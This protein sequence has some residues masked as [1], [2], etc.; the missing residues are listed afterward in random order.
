LACITSSSRKSLVTISAVTE[1]RSCLGYAMRCGQQAR[2]S[3]ICHG[4][5]TSCSSCLA[6][7]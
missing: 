2:P 6:P 5:C 7:S 1:S 4:M 3:A